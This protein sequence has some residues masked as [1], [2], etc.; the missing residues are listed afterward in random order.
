MRV[1]VVESDRCTAD[2]AIAD[3]R[4]AGHEVA[5]CHDSGRPAFPCNALYDGGNC[6]LDTGNGV[7]V[8][9]DYRAHPHPRPTPFEDGVSCVARRQIPVVVAGMSTLNP[10][11]KWTSAVADDDSI[12]DV[13]E[14]AASGSIE[15][16]AAVAMAKIHELLADEPAVADG[17]D[18]TVTRNAGTLLAVVE[19]PE[20]GAE[21]DA[22]LAVRVAG[23]IRTCDRW[24]PR[25][26][27][28]VRRL[29]S[30]IGEDLRPSTADCRP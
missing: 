24:T 1:L 17:A 16:L 28:C 11:E 6:T 22:S 29:A 5:R 30:A 23:A 10:F 2:R 25:I 26:D 13:C 15:S 9:L 27:V 7:D 12:V 21:V 19:L 4:A 20:S 14:R 8:L 3:L 18:V